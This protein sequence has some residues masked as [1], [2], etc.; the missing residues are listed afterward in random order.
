M[1]ISN[2]GRRH[3]RSGGYLGVPSFEIGFRGMSDGSQGAEED[4]EKEGR[5]EAVRFA[6]RR[7]AIGGLYR[8][9]WIA[10]LR[11]Q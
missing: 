9:P 2:I 7:G 4:G 6:T 8:G 1:T 3:G 10:L 5:K 11:S